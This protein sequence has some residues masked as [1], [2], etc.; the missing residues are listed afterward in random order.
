MRA[1][2]SRYSEA[3]KAETVA[4]MEQSDRTFDGLADDLGVSAWTLRH[5]YKQHQMGKKNKGGKKQR[6]PP[7]A[8]KETV[9]QRLA[10]LERENKRLSKENESLRMDR[11]ILKKAAAF[12]VK[13]S[14]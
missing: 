5:W 8:A 4:L 7:V 11:E 12:F 2:P 10:R 3:F 14:E 9:E 6:L 1:T 13:E